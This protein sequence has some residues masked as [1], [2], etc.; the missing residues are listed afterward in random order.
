MPANTEPRLCYLTHAKYHRKCGICASGHGD[1]YCAQV[2]M[3]AWRTLW[4]TQPLL[5]PR[6]TRCHLS[7]I[8]P[9]TKKGPWIV[10]RSFDFV[11]ALMFPVTL[12][13][14][15]LSR[16]PAGVLPGSRMFLAF[17]AFGHPVSV[18]Q[19]NII[20]SPKRDF[21][22]AMYHVLSWQCV[23]ITR[24]ILFASPTS[25]IM[26]AKNGSWFPCLCLFGFNSFLA[27]GESRSAVLF[28]ACVPSDFAAFL[29]V[30]ERRMIARV[31]FSS[32]FLSSFFS[33]VLVLCFLFF[34]FFFPDLEGPGIG[35]EGTW[36]RNAKPKREAQGQKRKRPSTDWDKDGFGFLYYCAF[37]LLCVTALSVCLDIWMIQGRNK[38]KSRNYVRG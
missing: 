22:C 20:A 2:M 25:Y 24:H 27:V 35:I 28:R 6:T 23:S 3:Y 19:I 14:R 33:L 4:L 38:A 8:S 30:R 29:A 31:C 10:P 26:P 13:A 16:L 11:R 15:K 21:D 36:N 5:M 9:S 37:G 7:N 12:C 34:F 1:W 18:I 17:V 32:F